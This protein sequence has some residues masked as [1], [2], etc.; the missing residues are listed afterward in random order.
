L[1][2][3]E[4]MEQLDPTTRANLVTAFVTIGHS[5]IIEF[6]EQQV[7]TNATDGYWDQDN[8]ELAK[9]IRET[10]L[11]LAMMRSLAGFCEFIERELGVEQ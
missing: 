11:K 6:H 5:G 4:Y 3:K 1:F 7:R 10:R 8:D 2:S 9:K